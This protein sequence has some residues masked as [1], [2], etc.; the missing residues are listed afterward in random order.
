MERA[1]R[2]DFT[3]PGW[4]AFKEVECSDI[5]TVIMVT[6]PENVELVGKAG[7]IPVTTVKEALDEA[8]RRCGTKTPLIT[9]M[10]QGAGTLPFLKS[11]S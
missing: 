2:A 4:V 8:Y 10:P 1:L 3:I 7:I 11:E 9:L 6:R 5:A